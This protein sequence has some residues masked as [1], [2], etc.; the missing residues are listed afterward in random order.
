MGKGLEGPYEEH[1]GGI[2]CVQLEETE[3]VCPCSWRALGVPLGLGGGWR[4][5]GVATLQSLSPK[6]SPVLSCSPTAQRGGL[7]GKGL[8]ALHTG[9][10]WD[11]CSPSTAPGLRCVP[12]VCRSS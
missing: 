1:L 9:V 4:C 8:L 12:A 10:P 11:S 2:W 6:E 3:E 7:G 5:L